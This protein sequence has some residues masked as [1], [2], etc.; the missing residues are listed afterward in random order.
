MSDSSS[1][2]VEVVLPTVDIDPSLWDVL[3][4]LLSKKR[5]LP[6]EASSPSAELKSNLSLKSSQIP[7][8]SLG[9]RRGGCAR[10]LSCATW[11][12]RSLSR[13]LSSNSPASSKQ[14]GSLSWSFRSSSMMSSSNLPASSKQLGSSASES[15][16]KLL[17]SWVSSEGPLSESKQPSPKL[18][19]WKLPFVGGMH[20]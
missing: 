18:P 14:L 1:L 10:Q 5:L 17:P 13:T 15:S 7:L 11:L 20:V 2:P 4:V 12:F 3:R 16:E 8:A 9:D 6:D 19:S